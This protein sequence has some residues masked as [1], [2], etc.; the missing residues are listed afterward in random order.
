MRTGVFLE[1]ENREM[2]N[3]FKLRLT[4]LHD[5]TLESQLRLFLNVKLANLNAKYPSNVKVKGC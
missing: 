1:I 5:D 3:T 4:L 2:S